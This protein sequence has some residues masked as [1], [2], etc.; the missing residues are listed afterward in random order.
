MQIIT[1]RDKLKSLEERF[2]HI[3]KSHSDAKTE[4]NISH[5]GE[6]FRHDVYYSSKL[7]IWFAFEEESNRYWNA[8]GIG[9]PGK[10]ARIIVEINIPFAGRNRRIGG[11]FV[12]DDKGIWLG[13]RGKIGGGARGVGYKA[14][15][16]YYKGD[17]VHVPENEELVPLARIGYIESLD[18]PERIKQFV[19][20]VNSIKER[21]KSTNP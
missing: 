18:F 20:E 5:R 11:V 12:E 15:W 1:D 7:D 9:R 21:S 17:V 6:V 19:L 14:F 13:H 16:K 8:F 2:Q 4:T 3:L 10:R